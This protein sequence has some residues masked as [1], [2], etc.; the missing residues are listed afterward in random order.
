IAVLGAGPIGL[1]AALYG[2]FLGYDVQVYEQGRVAGNVLSWGHVRM[3]SPFALNRSPLGLAALAAQDPSWCPPEDE[4][5]LTGNLF[6]NQYLIPL[7]QTD[8]LAD[9]IHTRTTVVAIGRSSA[10]KMAPVIDREQRAIDPFLLLVRDGDGVESYTEA[11]IVIDASGV[12]QNHGW[13]GQGGI[14]AVGETS[15]QSKFVYGLADVLGQDREHY[16]GKHT[17]VVGSGYS[18]ATTVVTLSELAE[19]SSETQVTW[20][21]RRTGPRGPVSEVPNDRLSGRQGLA[22]TANRLAPDKDMVC[23]SLLPETH[24]VAVTSEQDRFLVQLTGQHAGELQ[25]DR[26]IANVGFRPDSSIYRE[27]QVHQCYAS[28]AP[29]QIATT[30]LGEASGDCLGQESPPSSALLT[31]EPNFY[32][33]GNKSYGRDPRFLIS[34]GLEQIR[35]IFSVIVDREDLDL[36]QGIQTERRKLE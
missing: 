36:Y 4:A 8:L 26:V 2:R 19:Q 29:M 7:S 22:E 24:I 10:T 30:L 25:V 35:Q 14:P 21:T 33:L 1:E 3:F 13:M 6:A 20:V 11:D 9:H 15:L 12:Y 23:V 31:T 17:L 28:E 5:L 16:L 34:I 27:L 18:A 32:I